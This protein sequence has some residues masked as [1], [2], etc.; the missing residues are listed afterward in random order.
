MNTRTHEHIQLMR[1]KKR[2]LLLLIPMLIFGCSRLNILT[3]RKSDKK[4]A[5][6]LRESGQ[7]DFEFHT[8]DFEG[9]PIHYT[10]VGNDSLPLVVLV[11]GSPGSSSMFMDYLKD[12]KLTEKAQ[13]ISVD[14]PGFG[15]SG[16][17]KTE[18]SL[19]K[20]AMAFEEILRRHGAE[21]TILVGHSF[22][23]PVIARLAAEFPD[24]V[25]GLVMVAGSIDP[26]LEPREWW[27]KPADFFLIRWLTPPALKVCNQ[28]I[29]PLYVE[30]EKMLPLW[31]KI[32]CPV[33]VFHGEKDNLVP[34]E[35]A[36]FAQKMLINS[37]SVKIEMIEG[38]NHF[39]LWSLQ[40]LIVE[41][42]I[43]LLE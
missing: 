6:E 15:Y 18:R 19:E 29:L 24:L 34:K 2:Y 35:N 1:F 7:T 3:M 12:S 40:D 16:F 38:G 33:T 8:Y 41:E 32:T 27:R 9:R 20:Q 42:I 11:H 39:I 10:H 37:D 17:G 13:L 30:L 43:R 22:G 36:D 26:E 28:E 4:Q 5:K 25:Q 23:G 31:E 14:R 21:K